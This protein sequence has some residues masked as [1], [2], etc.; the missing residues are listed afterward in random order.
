MPGAAGRAGGGYGAASILLRWGA[1]EKRSKEVD[2]AELRD[3]SGVGS[4]LGDLASYITSLR[5]IY[6]MK[7]IRLAWQLAQCQAPS[8]CLLSPDC[9][10]WLDP[11]GTERRLHRPGSEKR[12]THEKPGLSDQ[13]LHQSVMLLIWIKGPQCAT[14]QGEHRTLVPLTTR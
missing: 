3:S 11:A 5:L 14:E 12:T 8:R 9:S 6:K 2:R 7:I 1:W 13:T 10:A 4:W